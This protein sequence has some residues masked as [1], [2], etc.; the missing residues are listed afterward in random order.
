MRVQK[1]DV[2]AGPE[3]ALDLGS[4]FAHYVLGFDGTGQYRHR[5]REFSGEVPGRSDELL[6]E[7]IGKGHSFSEIEVNARIQRLVV[8]KAGSVFGEVGGVGKYPGRRDDAFGCRF[9][10]ALADAAKIPVVVR[11][12][13]QKGAVRL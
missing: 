1:P 8:V 2:Q 6:S 10:N 5:H 4:P 3:A 9:E 13:D 12:D 7:V 11:V